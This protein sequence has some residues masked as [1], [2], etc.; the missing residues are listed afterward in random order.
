MTT[1][2]ECLAVERC[3]SSRDTNAETEKLEPAQASI[4]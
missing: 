1:W 2:V 4:N 3:G